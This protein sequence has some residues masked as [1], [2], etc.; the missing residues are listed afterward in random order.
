[1]ICGLKAPR[2]LRFSNQIKLQ[3]SF[4]RS[5]IAFTSVI[6]GNMGEIKQVEHNVAA[7]YEKLAKNPILLPDGT[8][9]VIGVSSGVVWTV[10][11]NH[12]WREIPC[13]ADESLYY[14]KEHGRNSYTIQEYIPK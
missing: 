2:R 1:M 9:K 5:I 10:D 11:M 14:V 12:D 13:A 8:E 3:Q 7:F 6:S 4:A